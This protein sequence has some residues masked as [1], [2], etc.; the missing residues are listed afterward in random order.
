M[1]E[2]LEQQQADSEMIFKAITTGSFRNIEEATDAVIQLYIPDP[3]ISRSGISCA[4]QR[5]AKHYGAL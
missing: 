3:D 4:F 2:T 5:L 1:T